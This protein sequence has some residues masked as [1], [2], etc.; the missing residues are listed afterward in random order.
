MPTILQYIAEGNANVV[1]AFETIGEAPLHPNLRNKLLRL[2]KDKS[3]LQPTKSQFATYQRE[4]VP[5]FRPENLVEQA[6]IPLDANIFNLLNQRLHEHERQDLRHGD[7]LAVDDYGLL[8]TDMTA[9][10]GEYLFEIKPKWLLQ[11][12]DAPQ[13]AIRCRT[14]ALKLQRDHAKANGA[15]TPSNP[16]AFCPLRLVDKDVEERRSAFESIVEAQADGLSQ[17]QSK[18][19]LL[20]VEYTRKCRII[21][22]T[23]TQ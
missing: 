16:A 21:A 13:D 23:I 5:L 22:S 15:V 18:S 2:R 10:H 7:G 20:L 11:S 8:M 19:Y 1:Y 14:C 9:K 12:P 3:F 6:L 4:I 17:M